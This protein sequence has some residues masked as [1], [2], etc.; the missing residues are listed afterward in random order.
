MSIRE[1]EELFDGL[2]KDYV[3]ADMLKFINMPS[4]R[5]VF[6]ESVL[7]S[8]QEASEYMHPDED[9][10]LDAII[11]KIPFYFYEE[12]SKSKYRQHISTFIMDIITPKVLEY[13][14]RPEV[15]LTKNVGKI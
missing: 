3:R 9:G 11:A 10:I 6:V 14:T 2:V 5:D 4:L 7:E 12:D 13:H 8:I 15:A 1:V